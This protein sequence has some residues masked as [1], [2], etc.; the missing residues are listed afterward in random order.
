MQK[1]IIIKCSLLVDC[2]GQPPIRDALVRVKE[3][4]IIGISSQTAF[5]DKGE[6]RV[7]D[8]AG[9]TLMPGF[10]DSHAHAG[11]DAA[12]EEPITVQHQKPPALRALRG[13][14]SLTKDLSAGTTTIRLLGDGRGHI[15]RILRETI[16][17]GEIEGPRILAAVQ[18]ILPTHGTAPE[19]G[20]S[21]DGIDQVRYRTRQAISLGA[22]VIKIFVSNIR[23]GESYIDY[24][25]GDLT[26]MPAFTREEIATAVT[27]AHRS[28]IKVAA[29]CLG[30]VSMDDAL[31]TGVDSIEHSNL[32]EERHIPLFLKSGAYLS[33]PNLILFFDA[34]R[35]F[36]SPNNKTHKWEQ[37]PVWWHEKVYKARERTRNVMSKAVREGVMFALGTDLNHGWLWKEAKYFITELGASNMQA[38]LSITK[39]GADLCGIG[40]RAGTLEE[41]KLADIVAVEGNPLENIEC[42]KNVRMVMKEGAIVKPISSKPLQYS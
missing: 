14:S 18:A 15:D 37:L 9:C 21:A 36:E 22:D 5:D 40:M 16:N 35:G 23:R 28:G 11:E 24:L 39:N 10:V 2:T 34:E 32:M 12:R 42:L 33:D 13:Y 25:H 20:V 26:D 19:I 29:H 3:N 4:L 17:S 31:E 30:G 27:E 8:L 38:I 6:S 41:G 7:I 1:Q